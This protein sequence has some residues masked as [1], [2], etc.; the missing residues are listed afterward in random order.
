MGWTQKEA[1]MKF[2]KGPTT[3]KVPPKILMFS[4]SEDIIRH[5]RRSPNISF[6]TSEQGEIVSAVLH[7]KLHGLEHGQSME[8]RLEFG[9]FLAEI[10]ETGL[11]F[12]GQMNR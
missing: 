11:T 9:C 4:L 5:G 10:I 12:K 3:V 6:G 1:G 2:K 8:I 7:G